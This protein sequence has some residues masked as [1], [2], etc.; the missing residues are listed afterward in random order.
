MDIFEIPHLRFL[1][2]FQPETA[3]RAG[4]LPLFWSGSGVEL[5][6]S[7]SEL[8]V[9]LEADFTE[10]APWVAAEVDGALLLRTPL[11]R[12]VN[13]LCLLQGLTAGV[14]RHVRLLKE[15][16]PM[17]EDRMGPSLDLGAPLDRG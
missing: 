15:T 13:E 17:P 16:Q 12:G 7:G 11:R 6:F 10:A 1:G 3:R 4:V 5:L 9:T 2:R 14:P 8:H